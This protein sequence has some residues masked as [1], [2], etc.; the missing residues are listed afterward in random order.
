MIVK[1]LLIMAVIVNGEPQINMQ[2]I[3]AD[4]SNKLETAMFVCQMTGEQWLDKDELNNI[5]YICEDIPL[6]KSF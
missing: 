4:Q 2:I 3:E 6:E 5:G 1:A